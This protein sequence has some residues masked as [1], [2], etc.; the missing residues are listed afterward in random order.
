MSD[1]REIA[2]DDIINEMDEA[3]LEGKKQLEEK[4]IK[5]RP[6][7]KPQPEPIVVPVCA[8]VTV[9]AG[10][11]VGAGNAN[12][13]W[14][15]CLRC[16]ESVEA[17]EVFCPNSD[18][19]CGTV[20]ACVRRIVGCIQFIVSTPVSGSDACS[21]VGGTSNVS[22]VGSVCVD[23]CFSCQVIEEEPCGCFNSVNGSECGGEIEGATIEPRNFVANVS[24]C[25]S[26]FKNITFTGEFRLTCGC[27]GLC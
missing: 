12:V 20:D 13:A 16:V 24:S 10:F 2:V 22:Y 14:V 11:V 4:K 25:G 19:S 1:W 8:T 27:G 21:G 17:V 18:R 26:N 5:I 3:S 9:P 15:N 7:Y 23:E 6:K